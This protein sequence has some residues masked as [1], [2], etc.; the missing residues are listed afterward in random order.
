M[1]GSVMP[2]SCTVGE[3][4]DHLVNGGYAVRGRASTSSS[5][6]RGA[7]QANVLEPRWPWGFR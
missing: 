6:G 2:D 5:E 4:G 3:I 1:T 7:G